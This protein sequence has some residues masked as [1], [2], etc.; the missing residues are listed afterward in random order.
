MTS[1]DPTGGAV[2]SAPVNQSW[3]RPPPPSVMLTDA[4]G[5]TVAPPV[6]SGVGAE[7]RLYPPDAGRPDRGALQTAAL[8]EHGDEMISNAVRFLQQPSGPRWHVCC[9]SHFCQLPALPVL[10]APV[11]TKRTFLA[12]KGL[13][14]QQVAEAFR[15]AALPP[16]PVPYR[17]AHPPEAAVPHNVNSVPHVAAGTSGVI[18]APAGNLL[19]QGGPGRGEG[20]LHPS[21]A[22]SPYFFNHLASEEDARRNAAGW[23]V[24]SSVGERNLAINNQGAGG[25]TQARFSQWLSAIALF[26]AGALSAAAAARFFPTKA[27]SGLFST[28]ESTARDCTHSPMTEGE[29]EEDE[30]ADEDSAEDVEEDRSEQSSPSNCG[31]S[32]HYRSRRPHAS[33]SPSRTRRTSSKQP[34][35]S[36][37]LEADEGNRGQEASPGLQSEVTALR[38]SL[39]RR[40]GELLR[41]MQQQQETLQKVNSLLQSLMNANT[42]EKSRRMQ[43]LSSSTT[44]AEDAAPGSQPRDTSLKRDTSRSASPGVGQA[45]RVAEPWWTRCVSDQPPEAE[46]SAFSKRSLDVRK[47]EDTGWF[48]QDYDNKQSGAGH[49]P[50]DRGEVHEDDH[51]HKPVSA[52][53]STKETLDVRAP[54]E[55]VLAQEAFVPVTATGGRRHSESTLNRENV[56]QA[57]NAVIASF[58]R[59]KEGPKKSLGTLLLMLTNLCS[60]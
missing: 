12:S 50:R 5:Q 35:T 30:D 15:R 34:L 4:R 17:V 55:A 56:L 1:A 48:P 18:Q 29:S 22:Y 23:P 33:S 54:D 19:L 45:D 31:G 37:W 32:I 10:S 38:Q 51:N 42:E 52:G 40:E 28:E 57:L 26:L 46:L 9:T 21:L 25:E 53:E 2:A 8:F 60:A 7:L 58:V 24:A 13:T 49:T 6:P 47:K 59:S 39:Q 27:F 14:D 43:Q 36:S 20:T 16:V 11:E 44:S 3:I 41:V